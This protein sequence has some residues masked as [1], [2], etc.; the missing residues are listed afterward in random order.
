MRSTTLPS[1]ASLVTVPCKRLT[2]GRLSPPPSAPPSDETPPLA[3]PAPGLARAENRRPARPNYLELRTQVLAHGV[4]ALPA[5]APW[6]AALPPVPP[7]A[8]LDL[9]PEALREPWLLH[10]KTS[11]ELGGAL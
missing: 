2:T 5:P 1:A 7:D 10:R 4:E 6:P 3:D 9:P 8:L 11:L